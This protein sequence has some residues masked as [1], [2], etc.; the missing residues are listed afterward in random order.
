METDPWTY[1]NI[2]FLTCQKK[3]LYIRFPLRIYSYFLK[4]PISLKANRLLFTFIEMA[5]GNRI[6]PTAT[7]KTIPIPANIS[8]ATNSA[9]IIHE[10]PFTDSGKRH[11]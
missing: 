1:A 9:V 4:Y 7:N 11:I 5:N 2:W 6:R 10:I 3:N 8:L